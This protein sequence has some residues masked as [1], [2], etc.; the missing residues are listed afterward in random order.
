V[1]EKKYFA[2]SNTERGF[3][4][5]FKELFRE[6]SDR[7]YIIKGGPGTGKSR[8]MR[9]MAEAFESCG[10][11]VEYYY[12]SSDPSSLDGLLVRLDG[13]SIALMDGTAPHAEDIISAGIVDNII[14]LGRFWNQKHLRERRC[15][16]ESL[17][18]EKRQAYES[19][20]RALAGYGYATRAGDAL[21]EA[22]VDRAA[23]EE[24]AAKIALNLKKERALRSPLS[25]IGM[26]GIVSFDSFE[27]S[28]RHTLYVSDH[29]S[30]GISYLYFDA[31]IKSVG[32][33]RAAPH[34]ILCDRYTG[35]ISGEIAIVSASTADVGE[36]VIDVCDFLDRSL[37]LPIKDR[38]DALRHSAG[39]ML[40]EALEAFQS[41]GA[42]HKRIE[43]IFGTAMD[44]AEKEAYSA[45]LCSKIASGDL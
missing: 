4:S 41:A 31:L 21:V 24:E 15:E 26:Q 10:S 43:E 29:R 38:A 36:K 45:Y 32:A 44:F 19:A 12:C 1:T 13:A 5:Y 25:A 28:A 30:Y 3:V 18:N 11:D 20:Y 34:P 16:I 40:S 14:D 7:C 33:C 23:I 42:A 27:A 35:L 6:R 39:V 8:L 22:C 9:E 17:T 37:Y 2:A